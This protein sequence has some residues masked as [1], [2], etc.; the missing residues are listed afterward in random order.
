[1]LLTPISLAPPAHQRVHGALRIAYARDAQGRTRL[2]DLYQRAP[3][4]VLF[5]DVEADEPPQAVLLTT[6]GGLTSGDRLDIDIVAR[7]GSRLTVST[8][9]AEKLYRA[10]AGEPDAQVAVN[11][12][13]EPGA[14]LEWLAQETILFDRSRLRRRI[15][16]ELSTDARLLA[17]ESVVFGRSAMGERYESGRL[18]EAWRVRRNGRLVWADALHLEGPMRAH[19]ETAF[20]VGDASACATLLYAGDDAAALLP[21]LRERLSEEDAQIA[22]ATSFDGL[23]IVRMLSA[24]AARLREALKRIAAILRSLALGL[25]DA[26][27]RVWTC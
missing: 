10:L 26:L 7:Q 17:T 11:L 12:R 15:D 14:T 19:R 22:A 2:A 25:P 1:M 3:C 6:S 5:P 27:P 23:L 4:R 24:D 13:V 9:A 16:V 20:A 21:A 18:H 8:Q